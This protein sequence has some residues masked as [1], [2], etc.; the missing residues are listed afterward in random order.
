MNQCVHVAEPVLQS[1]ICGFVSTHWT[2]DIKYTLA[3]FATEQ[4]SAFTESYSLSRIVFICK[5]DRTGIGWIIEHGI[6][7]GIGWVIE[8]GIGWVIEYGIGWVIEYG[9]GWVNKYG[10]GWVNKYGIGCG[11][12]GVV[13]S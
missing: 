13:Q 11:V 2:A 5:T 8:Y 12:R 10:I 1:V 9:I 4:L 7:Y 3:T 6:E